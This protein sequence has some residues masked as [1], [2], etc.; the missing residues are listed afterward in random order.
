MK[1]STYKMVN[2]IVKFLILL[3]LVMIYLRMPLKDKF[4]RIHMT[5]SV[6]AD[7]YGSIDVHVENEPLGVEVWNEPLGIEVR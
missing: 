4:G 5:G 6:D 1:E 7:C 3:V 2:L